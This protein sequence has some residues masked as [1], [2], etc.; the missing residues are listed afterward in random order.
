AALI[1]VNDVELLD[2]RILPAVTAALAP[3]GT[4]RVVGDELD[5]SIVVSRDAAGTILINNGAVPL[6]GATVANTQ[7]IFL[8]CGAGHDSLSLD[9]TNGALPLAKLD[10]GPGDDILSGG[11]AGDVFVG[12]PGN[13]TLLGGA[14]DDEFAWGPGD[15][16]DVVE[17]RGGSDRLA[18][19]G[20]DLAE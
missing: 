18:F 2:R 9:D 6:R 13:D 10:G 8:N 7:R 1:A 12:A 19:A 15:G 4:L 3:D 20:S 5:N 17:G 16:N 14:G 11:S